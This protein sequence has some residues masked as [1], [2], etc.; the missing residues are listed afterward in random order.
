MYRNST[1]VGEKSET[2]MASANVR[3]NER[4]SK[5]MEGAQSMPR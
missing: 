2:A 5:K 4:Y 1:M 3:V